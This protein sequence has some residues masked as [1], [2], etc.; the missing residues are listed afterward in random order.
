MFKVPIDFLQKL[1]VQKPISRRQNHVTINSAKSQIAHLYIIYSYIF[2]RG[3]K[4]KII[5]KIKSMF[6]TFVCCLSYYEKKRVI[7]ICVSHKYH[8]YTDP[9]WQ[10]RFHVDLK[11]LPILKRSLRKLRL[12]TMWGQEDD[13]HMLKQ[14]IVRWVIKKSFYTMRAVE[15]CK[16][17]PREGQLASL[18]VFQIQLDKPQRSPC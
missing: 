5:L 3:K 12:F 8:N 15:K 14:E 16:R 2:F 4:K 18:E 10:R 11:N 1:W 9:R 7:I 13:G 17:W 6:K